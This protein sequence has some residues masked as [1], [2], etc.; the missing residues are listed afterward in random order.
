MAKKSTP[1]IKGFVISIIVLVVGMTIGFILLSLVYTGPNWVKFIVFIV[2]SMIVFFLIKFSIS[3]AKSLHENK[4][5][6]VSNRDSKR[7]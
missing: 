5:L 6:D 4:N 1:S 7:N 2:Y 3:F